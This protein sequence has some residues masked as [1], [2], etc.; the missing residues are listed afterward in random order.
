[1]MS[2]NVAPFMGKELDYIHEAVIS[3]H[4]SG[5]GKFTKLCDEWMEK[6][7]NAER[8]MLTTSGTR[9]LHSQVLLQVLY[10]RVRILYL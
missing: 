10:L 2:F 6:R 3:R 7:F 9:A 8:V 1:M 5:D 4:I